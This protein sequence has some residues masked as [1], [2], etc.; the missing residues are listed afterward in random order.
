MIDRFMEK[1]S[2][3]P[4]T[5]CWLWSGS[6]CDKGYGMFNLNG[7]TVRAHRLSYEIHNGKIAEGMHILHKCDNP[8]C[9]NPEHLS[10]GTNHDNVKDKLSKRRDHNQRKTHCPLGHPYDNENTGVWGGMRYCK[11]C[12]KLKQRARRAANINHKEK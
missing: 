2:P 8:C 4:N 9:V 3:E 7:K 12:R 6:S 11:E 1:V 10:V 5:G